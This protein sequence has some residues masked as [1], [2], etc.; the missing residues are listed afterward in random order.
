MTDAFY[1]FFARDHR[2]R[3]RALLVAV[4]VGIV[5]GIISIISGQSNLAFGAVTV[6]ATSVTFW[7]EVWWYCRKPKSHAFTQERT[8]PVQQPSHRNLVIVTVGLVIAVSAI[9]FDSR[10]GAAVLNRRLL[11]LTQDGELPDDRAK[12]VKNCLD[13]A[14]AD[15]RVKL[16]PE[17]F[18]QV[19]KTIAV[20][21]SEDPVSPAAIGAAK[22]LSEYSRKPGL[23]GNMSKLRG[24]VIEMG[25]SQSP[26]FSPRDPQEIINEFTPFL[27]ANPPALFGIPDDPRQASTDDAKEAVFYYT[28]LLLGR[29]RAFYELGEF[30]NAIADCRTVAKISPPKP[31]WVPDIFRLM[32]AAYLRLGNIDEA[33]A[34]SAEFAQRTGNSSLLNIVVSNRSDPSRALAEIGMEPRTRP[35]AGR[36]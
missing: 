20:R 23:F 2:S 13:V 21:L 33:I 10:L 4:G 6:I 1:E 26:L 30:E 36:Q 32:V 35:P 18:T 34:A 31:I 7:T 12:I 28:N 22:S 19:Q 25:L 16:T 9:T 24:A 15:K 3:R 8:K 14:A 5:G 29:A 17:T 11:A 27:K